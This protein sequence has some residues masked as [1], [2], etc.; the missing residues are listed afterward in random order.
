VAQ[1]ADS[2]GES[3]CQLKKSL[4]KQAAAEVGMG[5]E[6]DGLENLQLWIPLEIGVAMVVPVG[7]GQVAPWFGFPR[8]IGVVLVELVGR[9]LLG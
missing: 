5:V 1:V 6:L 3:S 7:P 4:G 8:V 2:P 9:V